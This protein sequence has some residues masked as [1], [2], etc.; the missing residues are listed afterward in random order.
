M[1]E[2]NAKEAR[3]E[4]ITDLTIEDDVES[5]STNEIDLIPVPEISMTETRFDPSKATTEKIPSNL[6]ITASQSLSS[7]CY[8]SSNNLSERAMAE[9]PSCSN[10]NSNITMLSSTSL[11]HGNCIFNRNNTVATQQGLKTYWYV[12]YSFFLFFSH[13]F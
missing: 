12:H 7:D 5:I 4:E 6:K 2:S 3:L 11:L 9:N 13:S 10:S 8:D 1:Y